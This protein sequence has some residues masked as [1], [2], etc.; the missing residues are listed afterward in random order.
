MDANKLLTKIIKEGIAKKSYEI[1]GILDTGEITVA[2]LCDIEK[3]YLNKVI[4][5]N[6]SD[7][8]K[9]ND[10][11]ALMDTRGKPAKELLQVYEQNIC[12]K[13]KRNPR[14]NLRFR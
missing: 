1:T 9:F 4:N 8:E 2:I 12:D 6:K 11:M 14:N 10:V 3:E 13:S 7:S 5:S